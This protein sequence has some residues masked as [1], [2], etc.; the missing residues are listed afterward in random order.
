[1]IAAAVVGVRGV[2]LADELAE[3]EV[4]VPPRH[5]RVDQLRVAIAHRL[6]VDAVQRAG[7]R[8][9]RARSG[10]RRRTSAATRPP[11]RPAPPS[12]RSASACRA[13]GRLDVDDRVL[14]VAR[15]PAASCRRPRARS[16]RRC[17]ARSSPRAPRGRSR[18][19]RSSPRPSR[20]AAGADRAACRARPAGRRSCRPWAAGRPRAP[21][22]PRGRSR[23]ACGLAV[24]SSFFSRFVLRPRRPSSASSFFSVVLSSLP[25][26]FFSSS[27]LS[28]PSSSFFG[29]SGDG[30]SRPQ[31]HRD[32]RVELGYDQLLSKSL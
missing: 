21:R 16:R 28:S 2:E 29:A 27:F 5:R 13:S 6:P 20:S 23:P 10:R 26:S 1:M 22:S 31:R 12:R 11:D 8:R 4:D 7:R 19:A 32:E 17:R 14:L 3:H 15:R 24:A 18:R 9:S 25:S 30:T